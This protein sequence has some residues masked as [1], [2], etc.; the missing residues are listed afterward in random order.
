[1]EI[2]AVL[3]GA[4]CILIAG[5]WSFLKVDES[6]KQILAIAYLITGFLAG[7]KLPGTSKKRLGAYLMII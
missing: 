2:L 7:R 3:C 5:I 6:H 4:C 1:M